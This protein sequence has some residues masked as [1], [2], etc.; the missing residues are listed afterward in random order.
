MLQGR[1]ASSNGDAAEGRHEPAAAVLA[2]QHSLPE[3]AS[4]G[5]ESLGRA[6]RRS[7]MQ[8][9]DSEQARRDADLE[10]AVLDT[11]TDSVLTGAA[12]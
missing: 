4:D 2:E 10:A 9:T 11:L 3:R 7:S 5:G 8:D 6:S 1:E 12:L